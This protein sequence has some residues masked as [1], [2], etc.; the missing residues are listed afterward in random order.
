[1]KAI[2]INFAQNDF[3][4]VVL[5]KKDGAITIE[6]KEKIVSPTLDIPDLMEWMETQLNLLMDRHT[7]TFIGYKVSLDI[8]SVKQ[9]QRSYYPQAILNLI[10]RRKNIE[11]SGWARQ[12][13][14]ATKF[15]EPKTTDVYA[16]VDTILGRHP[17][18]WDKPTKDAL[19]VAWF[20]L[21]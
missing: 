5:S 18:H 13:I 11:I 2:G 4:V 8:S 3:R 14:N 10:A 21:L 1:M 20:K 15:G 9:I 6:T 12:G 17:P 19:L 7:P 16:Y